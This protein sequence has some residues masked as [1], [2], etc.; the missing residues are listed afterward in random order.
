ML[1]AEPSYFSELY[2][3]YAAGRLSP[4]YAL[5]VETQAAM[6]DDVR[7]DIDV[8]EAIAGVMFE[9]ED[10]D[11]MTPTAFEAA[12]RAIDEHEETEE[13]SVEAAE[14]AGSA[15]DE[16][17]GLPEPLR[18]RALEACGDQG[19]QRMT[20]GVSR[21]DL[22]GQGRTHAHLYRIQPGASVP[23]HSHRGDELTLVLRGGFSDEFGT[24]GPGQICRQTP[25]YTHKPVADDD[26][27]CICLAVSEGGMK[28]KGV[29]GL[30][31]RLTGK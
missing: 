23:T 30:L 6:R 2:S 12:L 3:A 18:E 24:Y 21:I 7:R 22:N 9:Q 13:R 25:D 17:L 14:A 4:A 5:M 20:A 11:P 8:A 19:W 27:V 28:F 29:L 10:I 15:L 16:L 31:Q 1:Q 26:G